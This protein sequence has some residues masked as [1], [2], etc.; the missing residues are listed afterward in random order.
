[1]RPILAHHA[2]LKPWLPLLAKHYQEKWKIQMS[3]V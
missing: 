1:M 2:Q 3:N